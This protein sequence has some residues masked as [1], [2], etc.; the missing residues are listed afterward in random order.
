MAGRR[1]AA[2]TSPPT[3]RRNMKLSGGT[4]YHE[5]SRTA[6]GA[7]SAMFIEMPH[8]EAKDPFEQ[9]ERCHRRLE[10][11]CDALGPATE[12]ADRSTIEDVARFLNRQIRRHEDDEDHSLFPRLA[13]R[14]ELK[15]FLVRLRGEHAKHLALQ[16]RLHSALASEAWSDLRAISDE[17]VRAY[18]DHIELEER[19]VFPV[20]RRVLDAS[21]LAAMREEMN[22]RRGK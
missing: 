16:E 12:T 19:E 1:P 4:P 18:R 7:E 20:A 5:T 3:K 15:E 10:E 21:A 8:D 22:A 6:L 14:E 9:L 2:S 11:A 17:L 13:E